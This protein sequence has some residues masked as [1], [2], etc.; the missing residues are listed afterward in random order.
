MNAG[1]ST[2]TAAAAHSRPAGS[3][4]A[5]DLRF[6][7]LT[8][9]G[10]ALFPL[11]FHLPIFSG[12]SA[13]ATQIL[14]VGIAAIGFNVLLGYAGLLSYGHAA[15]YGLGMYGAALTLLK[16]F[17][18][19][20]SFGLP[21]V[22]GV[23]VATI[24]AA[25]IGALVVRLYGIYFALLTVAFAQMVYFVIF[26]WRDVTRGDDG[27]QGITT[28]ALNLGFAQI[29]LSR[30]LPALN[31]GPFGD[32]SDIKLWY[33]FAAVVM[34]LVLAF[35]RTLVR[36]QFGEVLAA[37]RENEE[38]SIFIGFDPRSYK[39]AAF[40]ISGAICGLSGALRALY[41]GSAAIDSL[42]ISQ[43]GNLVIYTV[44][45]GVQTL[46]GPVVGTGLI[47][48]LQNV[49]SAKTDAWRLI[50]GIIFVAVIVFLPR[51]IIGSLAKTRFS[52]LRTLRSK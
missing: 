51:G 31:L 41:D 23:V 44:V 2:T 18:N 25:V 42:T 48:W 11:V 32:L 28:P 17:P 47:M 33:V 5:G 3:S 19:A 43:S 37:I 49:I 4:A 14:I 21:I 1:T 8:A 34:L 38:R 29:D 10:L 6:Y 20:H 24:V 9:L 36:S 15:F 13:L 22:V 52:F 39:F 16:F 50:E 46:F 27:L 26:E 45:G 35:V 40:V 30:T 7:L 12:Y